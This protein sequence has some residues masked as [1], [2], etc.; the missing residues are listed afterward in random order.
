MHVDALTRDHI[1]DAIAGKLD[2]LR[3]SARADQDGFGALRL[4]IHLDRVRVAQNGAARESHHMV[5][6]KHAGINGIEPGEQLLRQN[7]ADRIADLGEL[8]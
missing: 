4:A 8:D 7:H 5:V 1:P 6:A 2:A 3:P